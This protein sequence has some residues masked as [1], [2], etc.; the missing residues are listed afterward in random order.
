MLHTGQILEVNGGL[1][2]RRNPTQAEITASIEA[3]RAALAA[4]VMP[5]SD[6]HP[7]VKGFLRRATANMVII[8]G[9]ER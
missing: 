5:V 1:T 4:T 2:L 7:G 8:T 6:G 3:A 9:S